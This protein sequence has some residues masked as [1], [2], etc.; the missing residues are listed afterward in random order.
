M[1]ANSSKI[2]SIRT[3]NA[4]GYVSVRLTETTRI[5]GIYRRLRPFITW[6]QIISWC[7]SPLDMYLEMP[8][9]AFLRRVSTGICRWY[10]ARP[11]AGDPAFGPLFFR[12][13]TPRPSSSSSKEPRKTLLCRIPYFG[14]PCKTRLSEL[15]KSANTGFFE[16]ASKGLKGAAQVQLSRYTLTTGESLRTAHHRGTDM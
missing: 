5:C 13:V 8:C 12:M 2:S 6:L 9:G 11:P 15:P 14:K 7:R 10:C 1:T 3:R 4:M 16:V